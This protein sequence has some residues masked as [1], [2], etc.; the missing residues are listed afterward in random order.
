MQGRMQQ[1]NRWTIDENR[2]LRRRRFRW[3][4]GVERV[5]ESIGERD[6]VRGGICVGYGDHSVWDA[7]EGHGRVL[8]GYAERRWRR[9]GTEWKGVKVVT[10][11]VAVHKYFLQPSPTSNKLAATARTGNSEYRE[12]LAHVPRGDT[13]SDN[14]S[15]SSLFQLFPTT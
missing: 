2:V 11:M 5:V 15:S 13:R 9:L 4:A 1:L 3:R 12:K 7:G 8:A 10:S 14:S 6:V